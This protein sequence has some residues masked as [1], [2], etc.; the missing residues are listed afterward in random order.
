MSSRMPMASARKE[1]MLAVSRTV[2]PWAIWDLP[3]SSSCSCKPRSAAALAEDAF[4]EAFFDGVGDFAHVFV[5][6]A[7]IDVV[8]DA[9]GFSEEGDHV[10]G[11]AHGLAVGDLGFAF[12]E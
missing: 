2:S 8:A 12:V 7:E 4:A 10:G 11:F 1:I 9:D 6:F 5:A 3:S